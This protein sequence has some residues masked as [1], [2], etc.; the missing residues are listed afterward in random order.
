MSGRSRTHDKEVWPDDV[1]NTVL[2][3]D[4]QLSSRKDPFGA[5]HPHKSHGGG[6]GPLSEASDLYDW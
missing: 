1:T 4:D 3:T 5:T 2:E 6:K